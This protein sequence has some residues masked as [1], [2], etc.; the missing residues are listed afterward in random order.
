MV[1]FNKTME[2]QPELKLEDADKILENVFKESNVEPNSVPLEV[3]TAYSSYRKERFSLQRIVIVIIMVLFLLLPLLFVP[4]QFTIQA[5]VKETEINPTYTLQV[6]SR[7]PVKRITAEID[8]RNIPVYEVDAQVYSIEPA[9][10]GKMKIM[11]TLINNQQSIQYVDVGNVDLETPV[12]TSTET[13]DGMVYLHLSDTG[14]GIDYANVRATS[15][16]GEIV[17]PQVL[18]EN[19]GCIAFPYPNGT[20]NVYIPDFAENVL[21]LVISI[22][23]KEQ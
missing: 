1:F 17:Q 11:V 15:V 6:E 7:M 16:E 18:D 9:I 5:N 3:L 20:L 2:Q 22:G 12:L 21:Q 14:S 23:D 4:V 10:N 19:E 13:K 8:G